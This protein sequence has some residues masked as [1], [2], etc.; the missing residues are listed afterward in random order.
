MKVLHIAPT[1]NFLYGGTERYCFYL[2]QELAKKG[3]DVT[4]YSLS[5]NGKSF[6]KE[7]NGVRVVYIRGSKPLF[8]INPFFNVLN[9]LRQEHYDIIHVHSYVYFYANQVALARYL[10]GLSYILHIHGGLT[11][12]SFDYFRERAVI[13]KFYDK[14]LGYLTVRAAPYYMTVCESDK[15]L[16]VA[17]FGI[18]PAKVVNVGNGIDINKFK[19]GKREE[20]E[21]IFVGDLERWK[22]IV[23]L[24]AAFRE[25]QRR[26]NNKYRLTIFGNGSL[27]HL[28]DNAPSN[29]E[30][31]GEAPHEVIAKELPHY[32]A[33]VLPTYMEG[34]PNVV[35]EALASGI[36]VVVTP[37]GGIPE[38]VINGKNG[39]YIPHAGDPSLIV[40]SICEL[41]KIDNVAT[42][43]LGINARKMAKTMS[44]PIIAERVSKVYEYIRNNQNTT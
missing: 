24:I 11:P 3:Y 44:W 16:L 43:E 4:V 39:V 38:V 17:N 22:G 25:L 1:Y 2:T 18:S 5:P 37:V 8:R 15:R 33:L 40:K 19:P 31:R 36:P 34:M 26:F 12:I 42:N 6:E 13:K 23:E 32:Q 35:L 29:I 9:K 30:Y 21:F 20:G 10:Y 7:I 28:L 27:V 14:T 41:S